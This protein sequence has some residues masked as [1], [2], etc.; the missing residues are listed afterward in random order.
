MERVGRCG[1]LADVK[2]CCMCRRDLP[3]S[4]FNVKSASPDGVQNVCRDCNR[5]QAREYYAR[6]RDAHV[7]VV[8]ARTALMRRVDGD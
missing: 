2:E 1:Y 3:R 4:Q 7:R 5:A 8:M 6:N